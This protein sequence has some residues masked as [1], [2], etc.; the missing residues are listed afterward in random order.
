MKRTCLQVRDIT[1]EV[2]VVSNLF[3]TSGGLPGGLLSLSVLGQQVLRQSSLERSARRSSGDLTHFRNV[4]LNYLMSL[5][6]LFESQ[7]CPAQP[8]VSGS[9]TFACLSLGFGGE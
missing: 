8:W 2:S 3:R 6:M 5:Q 4:M 7:L 1:N 9:E